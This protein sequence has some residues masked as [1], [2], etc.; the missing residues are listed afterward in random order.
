MAGSGLAAAFAALPLP[1]HAHSPELAAVLAVGAIAAL[2]GFRWGVAVI[3]LAE[4]FLV[5]AVWPLAIL[6]RPPS[7][8]AQIAVAIACVGAVPGMI[9]LA[10]GG[11]EVVDL[12]GVSARWRRPTARALV[13]AS[14]ALWTWPAFVGHG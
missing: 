4:V 9:R 10:R 6:A 14:G 13:L 11:C 12:L 2:A 7:V 1:A 3:V 8:A 5:A